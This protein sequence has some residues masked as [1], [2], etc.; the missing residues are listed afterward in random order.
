MEIMVKNG[1]QSFKAFLAYKDVLMLSDAELYGLMKRSKELGAVTLAHCENGELIIEGQKR[2]KEL[3]I[4]GPEAHYLSRPET[5][6]AEATHRV[7]TIADFV[8]TP[9]FI[10]HVNFTE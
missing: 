1:I 8:N 2:M 5:I 10:V 3:G 9:L 6:E 7:I 4:L